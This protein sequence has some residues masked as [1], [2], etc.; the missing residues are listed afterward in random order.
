MSGKHKCV[1]VLNTSF[2]KH[3][4]P[5]DDMSTTHYDPVHDL[6][7]RIKNRTDYEY[8]VVKNKMGINTYQ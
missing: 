2:L 3:L 8:P 7:L 1:Y 5:F 4:E 6:M